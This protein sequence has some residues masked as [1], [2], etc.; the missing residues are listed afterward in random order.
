VSGYLA[1]RAALGLLT[2]YLFATLVFFLVQVVMPGDFIASLGPGIPAEER[3]EIV[4]ELGLDRPLWRQYLGWVGGA[5]HG[6]L[7]LAFGRDW[8][9]ETSP[10]GACS[11][12]G[13][14]RL[15]ID[16]TQW[17]TRPFRRAP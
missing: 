10:T 11:D 14:T 12:T 15:R 2:L 6:D 13:E 17:R 4:Q 3:Q 5:A 16:S 8:D 7:G 9:C 1:R